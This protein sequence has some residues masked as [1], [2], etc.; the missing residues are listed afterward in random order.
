M[1]KPAPPTTGPTAAGPGSPAARSGSPSVGSSHSAPAIDVALLA[2][3]V[4]RLFLADLS[5]QRRRAGGRKE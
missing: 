2:D 3:K 1:S 4:Y 5:L